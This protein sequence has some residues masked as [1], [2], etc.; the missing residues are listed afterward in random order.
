MINFKDFLIEKN[1][2]IVPSMKNTQT[3]SSGGKKG[4][5]HFQKYFSPEKR[6]HYKGEYMLAN[7]HPESGL[8][9]GDKVKL[10]DVEK[11]NGQYYGKFGDGQK[12]RMDDL[13]KPLGGRVGLNQQSLEDRQIAEL[14]K[15]IQEQI[16]KNGGNPIRIRTSDGNIHE[17]A[18]IKKVKNG[19][20]KADAYLHDKEG[21]PVHW[22]SLK[23]RTFQQ[24]AGTKGLLDHQPVK[25]AINGL[26]QVRQTVHNGETLPPSA[27][28]HVDLDPN[29][30][31]HR[32]II[33]KAMYGVDH[34]KEYGRNNVNAIYGGETI[35]IKKSDHPDANVFEFDPEAVY[36][37]RNDE[38]SDSV[39]SKILVTHRKGL[40][41]QETGGR[42]MITPKS[43]LPHSISADKALMPGYTHPG[44]RTGKKSKQISQQTQ[45]APQQDNPLNHISGE[46]GG[47]SFYSSADTEH[48]QN[49]QMAGA[50]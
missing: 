33:H 25:E 6:E 35:G 29:N 11:I 36:T 4:E 7:H 22:M 30:P 24:F 39:D 13:Y 5:E 44:R 47:T 43:F 28:Y 1:L 50:Q 19:F 27:A 16:Q 42:I 32:K 12:V 17:V 26:Q 37:N 38:N 14:H 41:Q 31:E 48:A 45:T 2:K 15:S 3:L 9:A 10:D 23:G 20:P 40:N 18:G 46:H 8:M 49:M 34:G 21:N